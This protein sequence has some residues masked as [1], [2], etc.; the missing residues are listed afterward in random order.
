MPIRSGIYKKMNDNKDLGILL[1][2]SSLPGPYGIGTMGKEAYAFVD[3]LSGLHLGWW[4]VLPLVQTGFGILPIS[5]RTAV[6]AIRIS[7]I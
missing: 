4:Q 5:R 2:V 7:L 6:R 3:F 1:H